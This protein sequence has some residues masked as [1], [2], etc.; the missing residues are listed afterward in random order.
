MLQAAKLL[1]SINLQRFR[2]FYYNS[3]DESIES[4]VGD[5]HFIGYRPGE[6][7]LAAGPFQTKSVAFDKY[8]RPG[9]RPTHNRLGSGGTWVRRDRHHAAS[10]ATE[11]H[12]A[13]GYVRGN[14]V[15][16]EESANVAR[17]PLQSA[18]RR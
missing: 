12:I 13:A 1:T 4:D 14:R 16:D 5:F 10:R 11:A 15:D 6:V 3:R 7:T 17:N 2:F 9:I 18:S 8:Q